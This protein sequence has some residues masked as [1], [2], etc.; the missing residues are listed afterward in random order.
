MPVSQPVTFSSQVVRG[1]GGVRAEYDWWNGRQSPWLSFSANSLG[2]SG[3]T[4]SWVGFCAEDGGDLALSFASP[5]APL[6]TH[7]CVSHN[8]ANLDAD[9]T[10]SVYRTSVAGRAHQV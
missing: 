2:H 5:T 7:S 4:E 3:E 8:R 9:G 1:G 6:G 10:K